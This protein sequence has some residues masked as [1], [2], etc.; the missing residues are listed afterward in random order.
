M[1]DLKFKKAVDARAYMLNVLVTMID[2]ELGD[3]GGWMFAGIDN[4]FDRRRL[5]NELK[6]LQ[7]RTVKQVQKLIAPK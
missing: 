6:K 5:T 3:E 7:K 4:E 2:H 1:A